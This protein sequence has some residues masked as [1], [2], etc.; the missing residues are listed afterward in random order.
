[1]AFKKCADWIGDPEFVAGNCRLRNARVVVHKFG[2]VEWHAGVRS[3]NPEDSY[4]V[5]LHFQ[6]K[7]VW[8]W[9]MPAFWATDMSTTFFKAF[10]NEDL[11]IAEHLYETLQSVSRYD[12]C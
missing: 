3:S 2:K 4:R 1:M 12:L 11:A 7:H 8:V 6:D 10:D 9:I 5:S